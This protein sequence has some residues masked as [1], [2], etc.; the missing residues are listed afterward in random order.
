MYMI[1][2][3]IMMYIACHDVSFKVT[4]VT[5]LMSHRHSVTED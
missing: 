4:C 5:V 3:D 2:T 1:F